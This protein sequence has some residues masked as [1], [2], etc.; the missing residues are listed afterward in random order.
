MTEKD[1][2]AEFMGRK[3]SFLRPLVDK[4]RNIDIKWILGGIT[5]GALTLGFTAA[6]F[7]NTSLGVAGMFVGA[8][9]ACL[10]IND[11]INIA[12]KQ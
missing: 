10:L 11:S 12:P 4:V 3:N 5:L 2:N 8:I 7:H 9:S 1:G 6:H